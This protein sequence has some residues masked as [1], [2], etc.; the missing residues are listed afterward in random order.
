MEQEN[1]SN[2][3][4]VPLLTFNSL[5]NLLREE[6]GKKPLQKLPERFYDAL[7]NYFE[8]KKKQIKILREKQDS[9][10]KI[11]KEENVY[12]NSVKITNELLS[13]RCVKISNIAVKNQIFGQEIFSCENVLEDEEQYLSSV[14][15]A[16]NGLK[17]R[18]FRKK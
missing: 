7:A 12:N 14:S 18:A 9:K 16:T 13:V 10:E 8:E 17:K 15:N 4:E 6:K 3:S 2:N 11:N 5:Y 1:D